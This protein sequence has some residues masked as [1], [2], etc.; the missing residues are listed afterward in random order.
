[1]H[2]ILTKQNVIKILDTFLDL[3]KKKIFLNYKS[4]TF[5]VQYSGLK[6]WAPNKTLGL[7][8][9]WTNVTV[10]AET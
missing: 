1:M 5:W 7:K 8:N 10:T 9:V 2:H 4:K 3:F 6:F